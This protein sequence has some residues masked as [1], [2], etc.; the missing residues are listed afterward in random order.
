VICKSDSDA[1]LCPQVQAV[2]EQMKLIFDL[3]A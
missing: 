3:K 1:S 2:A